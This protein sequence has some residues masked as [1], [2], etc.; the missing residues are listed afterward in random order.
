MLSA[1]VVVVCATVVVATAV[2]LAGAG[3]AAAVVSGTV[4]AEAVV[5]GAALVAGA[6]VVATPVATGSAAP[7]ISLSSTPPLHAETSNTP[8][9][10]A[11]VNFT[12]QQSHRPKL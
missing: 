6:T 9:R 2:V 7:E 8:A 10:T 5:A 1:S 12:A 3:S 4:V 11:N